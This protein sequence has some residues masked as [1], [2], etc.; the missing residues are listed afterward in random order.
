MYCVINVPRNMILKTTQMLA[1]SVCF[2]PFETTYSVFTDE[3]VQSDSS[4][5]YPIEVKDNPT[6]K[7]PDNLK[8][9]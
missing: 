5:Y 1:K 6:A 3:N 8:I 7:Y 2:W 4:N 9:A